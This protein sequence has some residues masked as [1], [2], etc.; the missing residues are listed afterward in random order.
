MNKKIKLIIIFLTVLLLLPKNVFAHSAASGNNSSYGKC[1]KNWCYSTTGVRFSLYTYKNGS[2]SYIK[3][4]DYETNHVNADLNKRTAKISV[5]SAGKVAYT[6]GKKSVNWS[7][8]YYKLDIKNNKKFSCFMGGKEGGGNCKDFD[9]ALKGE[10]EDTFLLDSSDYA[11]IRKKVNDFFGSS[12]TLENLKYAYI[13]VE[14]TLYIYNKN[15]VS[16]YG[17]AYELLNTSSGKKGD[18]F[19]GINEVLYYGFPRTMVASKPTASDTNKFVSKNGIVNLYSNSKS[20]KSNVTQSSN[21]NRKKNSEIIRS[22][23][24]YGIGVFWVGEG[25]KCKQTCSGKSGDSLLACAE[26]YCQ[27]NTSSDSKKKTCITKCGYSEPSNFT[28]SNADKT[29]GKTTTTVCDQSVTGSVKDCKI[30]GYAKYVCTE[31]T[32]ITKYPTTQGIL[33]SGTNLANK[34]FNTTGSRTCTVSLNYQKIKFDYAATRSDKTRNSIKNTAQNFG[35]NDF[36]NYSSS[37]D[38][39]TVKNGNYKIT[40]TKKDS[41]SGSDT[42]TN[43]Q[44]QNID[45]YANGS[46]VTLKNNAVVKE[47][48]TKIYNS[49][50]TVSGGTALSSNSKITINMQKKSSGL[51]DTNTCAYSTNTSENFD[52]NITIEGEQEGGKYLPGV[53][54]T[55]NITN[56]K[57][58]ALQYLF[59]ENVSTFVNSLS[60]TTLELTEPGSH[61]IVG[62]VRSTSSGAEQACPVTI[63]IS[64]EVQK[65]CSLTCNIAKNKAEATFKGNN[66][67]NKTITAILVDTN[68]ELKTVN[69]TNKIELDSISLNDGD[70]IKFDATTNEGVSCTTTCQYDEDFINCYMYNTDVDKR[71]YCDRCYPQNG[72]SGSCNKTDSFDNNYSCLQACIGSTKKSCKYLGFTTK[73]QVEEWYYNEPENTIYSSL[74]DAVKSCLNIITKPSDYLYRPISLGINE[75]NSYRAFPNREA[76]YNWINY[77]EKTKDNSFEKNPLYV[78]ELDSTSI[79]KIR[80]SNSDKSVYVKYDGTDKEYFFKSSFVNKFYKEYFTVINGKQV[81]K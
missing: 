16:Y 60:N 67:T 15:G 44:T 64:K 49:T 5:N 52:C 3:S 9:N 28:C 71:D 36:K 69:D 41:T 37:W 50:F 62:K 53:K 73:E 78:I 32:T 72:T 2:L 4:V 18:S 21:T 43:K 40:I 22:T 30:N 45:L 39:T 31:T 57:N 79:K 19:K 54:V 51:N 35:V 12:I 24:G 48:K 58:I 65:T 13:T 55:F 77:K 42:T 8:G 14:P 56:P 23:D 61:S 25:M 17:T 81:N 75:D 70:E 59:G 80:E 7:S 1:G 68:K 27:D 29:N 66:T 33:K 63:E 11:K 34:S 74:D 6:S 38:S 20:L 76:G 47:T 10:I 26:D 46:K